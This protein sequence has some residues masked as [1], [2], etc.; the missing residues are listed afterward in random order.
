MAS[1]V[2]RPAIPARTR[3]PTA[4]AKAARAPRQRRP[5]VLLSYF[6]P[7]KHLP[8]LLAAVKTSKVPPG[9]PVYLGTYGL[10]RS[11]SEAIHTALPSNGKYAP[12]FGL[13]RKKSE[14]NPNSYWNRRMASAPGSAA[15]AGRIPTL[16]EIARSTA[17]EG[18]AGALRV[19]WGTELGRRMRDQIEAAR[20]SGVKV[21]SWQLDEL[22]PSAAKSAGGNS[23]AIRQLFRG[24]MLGLADGRPERNDS[25]MPGMVHIAHFNSL[26]K[27]P[28]TDEMTRFWKALN[29]STHRVVGEVYP[30]FTGDARAKAREALS[31]RDHLDRMSGIRGAVANKFMLGMTPGFRRGPGLGGQADGN[32]AKAD[33]W[34]D[35]FMEQALKE[36]VTGLSEYNWMPNP[37]RRGA[38]N[39]DQRVMNGILED[40]AQNLKALRR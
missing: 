27:L 22:W 23:K 10:S 21:D 32:F 13:V 30:A 14:A 7:N 35:A 9:V 15:F 12:I 34:R 18:K 17:D 6:D 33:Q 24:V 2:D 19:A 16:K 29:H 36:G 37:V 5:E 8:R 31:G 1:K 4:E 3:V 39:D 28:M 38:Q 25:K 26:A 20:K 40:I 11:Q